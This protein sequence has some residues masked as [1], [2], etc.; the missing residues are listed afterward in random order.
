MAIQNSKFV[1]FR[2]LLFFTIFLGGF[3]LWQNVEA[4]C[5][6]SS[7][8]WTCTTETCPTQTEVTACIAQ[9][10]FL[11]GD[12]LNIA[13]GAYSWTSYANI[14][15]EK[16][17]TIAGA[18]MNDTIIT[19]SSAN[20]TIRL[21]ESGSRITAIGFIH[22]GSQTA[23]IYAQNVDWRIDHCKFTNNSGT[24]Q[25]SINADGTNIT[26]PPR[27]LIDNNIFIN[28]RV[29]VRGL[30]GQTA[31]VPS[32]K[33]NTLWAEPITFGDNDA[34]YIEDCNFSRP[35]NLIDKNAIDGNQG[36]KIVFRY[37]ILSG[38]YVMVHSMQ[39]SDGRGTKKWEF[40]GN[41]VD[42]AA[43]A[44]I[45]APFWLRGGT[46]FVF[47]N[48]ISGA[49]TNSKVAFDNVRSIDVDTTYL[50]TDNTTIAGR[51]DGD[52]DYDGN[53]TGQSG[54]PC[55]DQ[56]GR[57]YDTSLL[58]VGSKPYPAQVSVPAYVWSNIKSESDIGVTIRNNCS[59]WIQ[60]DRDYYVF[61][62]S[63]DG[64]SGVGCGTLANRPATCTTGVGYWATNQSCSDMTGMVGVN[65]ET[66]IE[67][68]LYKC[69]ATN[70]WTSYYTPYIYPH[71]LRSSSDT[72]APASPTG[73]AVS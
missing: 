67:G 9:D 51:C 17:I 4:A 21:N 71:P 61:S 30:S 52:N 53:T 6:G 44:T 18:G 27:G 36:A 62:V 25:A 69:T 10:E 28:G 19:S 32:I 57:G 72:I 64:T 24:S 73:L 2:F 60:T 42:K 15:S 59:N 14:P 63:F 54:W 20:Y 49:F 13:A 16:K 39:S 29:V 37:N 22:A 58:T 34:V 7:P 11:T 38:T 23:I 45:T 35:D 8:T 40:Y 1:Y 31:G 33:Q 46:G 47:N 5:T 48:L 26:T 70:T 66:P 65:P 56:I 41:T 68:T 3:L 12:T 55:R 43:I 50:T